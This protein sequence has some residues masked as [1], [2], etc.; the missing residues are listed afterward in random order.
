M[1]I[2]KQGLLVVPPLF[3]NEKEENREQEVFTGYDCTRC[4]GLGWIR[5]YNTRD[6]EKRTC[7]YCKGAKKI[8]AVAVITWYPEDK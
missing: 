8:K 3:L 6:N 5:D 2:K 7:P 1:S 4:N